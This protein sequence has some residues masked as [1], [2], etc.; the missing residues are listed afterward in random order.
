MIAS[1]EFDPKSS[2][3]RFCFSCGKEL[4]EHYVCG[5]AA[6]PA[7]LRGATTSPSTAAAPSSS[8]PI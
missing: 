1:K 5:T 8:R 2:E 4:G 7:A 6:R 3:H